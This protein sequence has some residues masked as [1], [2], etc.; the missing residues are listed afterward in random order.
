MKLYYVMDP[1]CSWCYGFRPTFDELLSLLPS[2]LVVEYVMGGLA[3]D[4]DEPMTDEMRDYIQSQWRA[5]EARTG[6]T[7]NRDF[8]SRCQ[9][10][11]ST[12]PACR[13]VIAA[14]LQSQAN[15]P[16]M[17]GAIQR[18]YYQQAR[19][20]SDTDTLLAL[21]DEL[22]LDT[23]RFANNLGSSTVE[24][25]LQ[26]HLALRRQLDVSSF[27]SLRLQLAND[28]KSIEID[29]SDAGR[30]YQQISLYIPQDIT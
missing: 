30:V 2:D 16:R 12:Y 22:Q 25:R 15:M 21:A 17:I 5:V 3:A 19:N 18:A 29:Y 10:R 11:R 9:P 24:Q 13:A 7:F 28:I 8:W 1:M 26:Q 14:G 23:Q 27:P 20:P 6:A 4:S